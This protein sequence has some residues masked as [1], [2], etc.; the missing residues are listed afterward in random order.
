MTDPLA[1]V[2]DHAARASQPFPPG[3]DGLV[4]ITLVIAAFTIPYLLVATAIW[5]ANPSLHP[6]GLFV[7]ALAAGACTILC[8]GGE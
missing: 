3:A 8:L 6:F 7:L 5:L 4:F 2:C 1:V